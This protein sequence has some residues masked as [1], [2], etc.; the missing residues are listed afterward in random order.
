MLGCAFPCT[1][2]PINA[3]LICGAASILGMRPIEYEL[4]T[5]RPNAP[6]SSRTSAGSGWGDPRA[7]GFRRGIP[8]NASRGRRDRHPLWVV[9]HHPCLYRSLQGDA[10]LRRRPPVTCGASH[11]TRATGAGK[12]AMANHHYDP[13]SLAGLSR[14]GP[15]DAALCRGCPVLCAL[16]VAA[17]KPGGSHLPS[18]VRRL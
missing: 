13:S 4:R 18:R 15:A 9:R 17:L 7:H 10:A 6:S 11:A 2:L 14:S 12:L 5:A 8:L 1:A 3:D 16:P